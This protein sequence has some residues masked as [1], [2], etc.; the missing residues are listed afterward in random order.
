MIKD[1]EK[2]SRDI[3]KAYHDKKYIVTSNAIY[4]PYYSEAQQQYYANKVYQTKK[5]ENLTLRGRFFHF[6]GEEVNKLLGVEL[7]AN[8]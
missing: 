3:K 4:Q 1:T 2:K 6:T 7:L 8:L 5:G